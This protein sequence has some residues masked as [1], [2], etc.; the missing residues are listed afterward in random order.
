MENAQDNWNVREN[1]DFAGHNIIW[2]HM[3][4]WTLILISSQYLL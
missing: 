1:G 3:N 2:E 4:I